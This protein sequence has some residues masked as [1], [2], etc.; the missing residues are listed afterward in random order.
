M[1]LRGKWQGMWTIARLNWPLYVA[2]LVV[3]ILGTCGVIWSGATLLKWACTVAVAGG[4]YFLIVSL[5]VSH[6]VYDR[7]DLYRWAWLRRALDGVKRDTMIVCHSGFDEVSPALKERLADVNWVVLD[8]Y[9]KAMMTEASIRR[10]RKR[11]PQTVGTK[12]APFDKWPVAAQSVDV[13][14]GLLAIHE[15][16]REEARIA[17]FAEARRCL[18]PRGRVVLVE[19]NRDLANFLAFGPGF[20]HFHSHSSWRRCWEKAGL[21]ATDEFQ[22]T[23]WVRICIVSKP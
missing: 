15:L 20:M 13:V 23:P 9:D 11:F 5:W 17:W 6:Q 2:A 12:S 4:F 19:H 3:L 14:F 8:H 22:V 1:M 10:A 18:M 16:R 7:S 21:R